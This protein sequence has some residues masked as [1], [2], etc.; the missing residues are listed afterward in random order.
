MWYCKQVVDLWPVVV[1]NSKLCTA[2]ARCYNFNQVW[3]ASCCIQ[4][5]P[6]VVVR[7]GELWLV[8]VNLV[9]CGRNFAVDNYVWPAV[10]S[11]GHFW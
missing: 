5:G 8:G 6:L 7:Y 10:G 11:Q 2:I 1:R 9:S 4:L 3:Y